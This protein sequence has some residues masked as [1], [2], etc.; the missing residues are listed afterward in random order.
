MTNVIHTITTHLLSFLFCI[1]GNQVL[2]TNDFVVLE[3]TKKGWIVASD[4]EKTMYIS[5]KCLVEQ[6][7]HLVK[8]HP[9]TAETA[10]AIIELVQDHVLE[11][12]EE[13]AYDETT[14]LV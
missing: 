14:G 6:L 8:S 3:Y 10:P 11:M 5:D 9:I 13:E 4:E 2:D 7:E 1:K 12:V